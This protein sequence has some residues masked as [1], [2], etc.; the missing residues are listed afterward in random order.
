MKNLG[1][2]SRRKPKNLYDPPFPFLFVF[3]PARA[4]PY[5]EE[6]FFDSGPRRHVPPRETPGFGTGAP[7][8]L[9]DNA[10]LGRT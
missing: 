8:L 5:T 4:I 7:L 6:G 3:F 10:S 1:D 2:R 9:P